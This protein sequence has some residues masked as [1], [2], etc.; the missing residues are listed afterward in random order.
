MTEERAK[1]DRREDMG[2]RNCLISLFLKRL[3]RLFLHFG[4][5]RAVKLLDG[6]LAAEVLGV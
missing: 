4:F 3:G 5:P 2:A 6:D 1:E